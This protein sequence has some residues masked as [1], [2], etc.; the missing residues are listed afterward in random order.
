MTPV[1][2]ELS[3]WEQLQ[4]C[5]EFYVKVNKHKQAVQRY[6]N[7]VKHDYCGRFFNRIQKLKQHST[8]PE[9]DIQWK[10]AKLLS[11]LEESKLT[12]KHCGR[13]GINQAK[14]QSPYPI[15]EKATTAVEIREDL[16][17]S[18]MSDL[19]RHG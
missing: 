13:S 5:R 9:E 16:M 4:A 15:S 3:L 14:Q 10:W 19:S 12:H 11:F 17:D 1:N 6:I 7:G 18:L 2:S 8:A